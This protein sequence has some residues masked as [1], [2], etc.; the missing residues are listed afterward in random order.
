MRAPHL[1]TTATVS[2]HGTVSRVDPALVVLL[3]V[4]PAEVIGHQ[5]EAFGVALADV[6]N[7]RECLRT[8]AEGATG[9]AQVSFRSAHDELH[10]QLVAMAT[11][12]EIAVAVI[13]ETAR[14]QEERDLAASQRRWQ[15]LVR[16]AADIVFTIQDDGTLTS[17]TSALPRRMGWDVGDVV[18]QY[19]L[20]FV[21][22]ADRPAA[23]AA[24]EAVSEG[25]SQ[26][27]TL[28]VRL[29]HADRSVTWS[30]VVISDLRGDPDVRAVVGNTTDITEQKL[31]QMRQ[32][33]EQARFR[34]RFEQSRM[35]QTTSSAHSSAAPATS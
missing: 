23:G 33:K 4:E 15:S 25:R 11:G 13:D 19:G 17:V 2:R 27:E 18:G 32:H 26:Q 16:N 28:E 3:G 21:D 20:R 24:W 12:D 22:A 1:A 10:V 30:R 35:P 7:I 6:T 31:A 5:L 14:V 29:V 9:Q 34:A 8:A